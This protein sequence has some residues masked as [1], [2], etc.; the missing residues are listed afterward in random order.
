MSRVKLSIPEKRVGEI[1][2]PVRIGDINYGNHVGND[3][4]VSIIHEARIRWLSEYGFS[5]LD[6]GGTGLIMSDLSIEFKKEG[7]YGDVIQVCIYIG[8]QT[9]VGFELYYQLFT[10]R[11]DQNILLVNAKTGIVC[12]DY[13]NKKVAAIPNAFLNMLSV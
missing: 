3:S 2:I 9:L 1:I 7:I 4:F 11:T 13:K 12:Y 10:K 6:I 5:E 8:E